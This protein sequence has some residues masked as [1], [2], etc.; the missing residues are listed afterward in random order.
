MKNK[1]KKNTFLYLLPRVS[2]ILFILFVSIFA[3]DVFA[4]P[5][6]LIGLIIHLIPSF[7]LTVLTILA[8]KSEKAGGLAF[9]LASILSLFFF[10]STIIFVPTFIIGVLFLL[11]YRVNK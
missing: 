10:H 11:S 3:L 9:I 7:V 8:W 4:D 1:V 2:A 5:K 6:W